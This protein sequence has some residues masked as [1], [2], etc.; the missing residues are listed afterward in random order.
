MNSQAANEQP[1]Q[2]PKLM[3]IEEVIK[4]TSL[5]KSTIYR[6][7]L[8]GAF[9]QPIRLS[10]RRVAWLESDIAAHIGPGISVNS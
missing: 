2:V 10:T 8:D 5:S 4:V 3:R 9:P 7:I 6:M 1:S